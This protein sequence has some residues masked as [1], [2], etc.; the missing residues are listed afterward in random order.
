M[1]LL[2]VTFLRVFLILRNLEPPWLV[3][4]YQGTPC[5]VRGHVMDE[6]IG[7]SVATSGNERRLEILGQF[8]SH[9]VLGSVFSG[10]LS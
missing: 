3:L 10:A 8:G 9:T 7:F 4:A 5:L 2:L 1:L 6:G